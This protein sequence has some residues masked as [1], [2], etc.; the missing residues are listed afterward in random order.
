MN[1]TEILN[2]IDNSAMSI[3]NFF[4]LYKDPYGEKSWVFTKKSA[5]PVRKLIIK[6]LLAEEGPISILWV[7][8]EFKITLVDI[9]NLIFEKSPDSVV[10]LIGGPCF[11]PTNGDLTEFNDFKLRLSHLIATYHNLS[12]GLAESRKRDHFMI[13]KGTENVFIYKEL[14]HA[15]EDMYQ[16]SVII[17]NPFHEVTK[18]FESFF[19]A[20]KSGV[21]PLHS[22]KIEKIKLYNKTECN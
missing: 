21:T 13:I 5:A 4:S 17:K 10:N 14:P 2:Q 18:Y 9:L 8:G 22:D 3:L 7:R 20:S 11:I 15:P 16:N 12:V 19:D 1:S 6:K